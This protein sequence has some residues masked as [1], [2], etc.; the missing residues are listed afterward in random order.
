MKAGTA[1][2]AGAGPASTFRRLGRA[3]WSWIDERAGL[4]AL[5]YPVPAH[6]NALGYTLGGISFIGFLVLAATGFW[7]VQFYD[8]AADGARAS[9]E[10]IQAQAPLGALMR[11]VH[12][13]VANI[14]VVTVFLHLVRVY[15]TASYKRPRELNWLVG[16]GLFALT[17][18]FAF[19]GTVL[20]WDQEAW[21]ALQ[22][23]V[24]VGELLGGLGVWFSPEFTSSVPILARLY[25]AHVSLLPLLATLAFV[26]HFLL[27]KHHGISP[28][29]AQVD[30]GAAPGGRLPPSALTARFSAHIARM[31]GYGA[32]VAVVAALAGTVFRPELGPAPDP[33]M[34]ITKPPF[35]FYPLY[36]AENWLGV[37]GVLLSTLVTFGLL[38]VV[39]LLD[40]SPARALRRRPFMLVLGLVALAAIVVLTVFVA[41]TPVERH[42]E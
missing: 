41:L 1:N 7:L 25:A 18:A 23:N 22:H 31:V 29:P 39:P 36:A 3:V 4:S 30:A 2:G 13:W 34:E 14:V 38:V 37:R 17:L 35:Y 26:A 15:V 42:L 8:P 33:S 19:T 27:V 21:E 24:E 9:V 12:F 6:G 28:L 10:F 20:K 32:V 40:R 16:V 5:A 11:G